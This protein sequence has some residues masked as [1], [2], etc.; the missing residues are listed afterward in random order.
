[1]S[2][3]AV[4]CAISVLEVQS[5]NN[6][7]FLPESKILPPESLQSERRRH[8]GSKEGSADEMKAG[9]RMAP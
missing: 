5:D 1:M 9:C 4:I 3:A 2:Q 7:Q 6:V 8:R